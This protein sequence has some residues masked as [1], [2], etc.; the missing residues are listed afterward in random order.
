METEKH[1][2]LPVILPIFFAGRHLMPFN[3][4]YL[5][6]YNT[7]E[8]DLE[9]KV[10]I[11]YLTES[12]MWQASPFI[13]QQPQQLRMTEDYCTNSDCERDILNNE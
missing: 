5:A 1:A 2:Y 13:E 11:T 4:D 3:N 7:K 8:S 10:G 9:R 6:F 12:S